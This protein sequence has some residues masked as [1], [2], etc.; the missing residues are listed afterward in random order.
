MAAAEGGEGGEEGDGV[1]LSVAELLLNMSHF[2]GVV[3]DQS[4]LDRGG[5]GDETFEQQDP[6]LREALARSLVEQDATVPKP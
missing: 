6:E 2:G 3:E 4:R 5:S 1:G